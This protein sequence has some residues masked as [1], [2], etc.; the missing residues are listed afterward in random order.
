MTRTA[1]FHCFSGVSGDMTLGAL[2][3]AGAKVIG[4]DV[5]YPTSVEPFIRGFERDFLVGHGRGNAR[6]IAVGVIEFGFDLVVG[7][8][9]LVGH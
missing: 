7:G 2:L 1:W 6:R 8:H 9:G 4:F 5:V 3:D